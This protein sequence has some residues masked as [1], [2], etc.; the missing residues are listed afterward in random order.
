MIK[1]VFILII[2]A[3]FISL[4]GIDSLL[5]VAWPEMAREFGV[6]QSSAGVISM[7]IGTCT[8]ISSLQAQRITK[9]VGIGKLVLVSMFLT[10]IGLMG[11]AF[12]RHFFLLIFMAL[13]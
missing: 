9:K 11:F 8:I 5:G 2:Y 7:T 3:I 4:G 10:A 12:S 1:L 13:R 6:A